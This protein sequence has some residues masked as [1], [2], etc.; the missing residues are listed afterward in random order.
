MDDTVFTE[1]N[2]EKSPFLGQEDIP[3]DKLLKVLKISLKHNK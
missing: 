1:A 2:K 3:L